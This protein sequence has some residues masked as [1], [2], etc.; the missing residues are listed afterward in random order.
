MFFPNS[1]MIGRKQLTPTVRVL[2]DASDFELLAFTDK[3]DE[4]WLG[5][6]NLIEGAMY[7]VTKQ[8]KE[9][10]LVLND[11]Q[12]KLYHQ[13]CKDLLEGRACR[14]IILKARQLG[15]TTFI[16]A[17]NF[18]LTMFQINQSCVVIANTADNTLN[19]FRKYQNYYNKLKQNFPPAFVPELKNSSGNRME[20]KKTNCSIRVAPSTENAVVGTTVQMI[21]LSE[22]GRMNNMLE[23]MEAILAAVPDTTDNPVTFIFL[24]STARGFNDFKDY[25]DTAVSEQGQAGSFTPMFFP[26]FE[27]KAYRRPVPDNFVLLPHEEEA[28]KKYHLDLEQLAFYREKY[29][30]YKKNL[31]S[32]KQEYPCCPSEAFVSSGSGVFDNDKVGQRKDAVRN[33]K[34]ILGFFQYKAKSIN[35][36]IDDFQIYD[37]HFIKNDAGNTK[38]F[39][40]PKVGVPYVIGVDTAEGSGNDS[41][42]AWVMRNDNKKQVAIMRS[43]ALDSDL[44]ALQIYCLGMFY[45][46]A[47]IGVEN[48]KSTSITAMIKKCNYPNMYK[49]ADNGDKTFDNIY[50]MYG[51]K[52][53]TITKPIMKDIALEICRDC[54]YT[55]IYD[56]QTLTEMESFVYELSDRSDAVKIRGAGQKHDDCVMAMLITYYIANQQTTL[57]E[58]NEV[59]EESKLPFALQSPTEQVEMQE[60]F[61]IWN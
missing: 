33:I 15:F 21:H 49:R 61:Q 5:V 44:A 14:Y 47:L 39:E 31:A 4:K 10:T 51:V 32:L 9:T 43:N 42:V 13:I 1:Q 54:D 56:Y 37:K 52:T 48:N 58:V 19:I 24:E 38:I 57:V 35:Q 7:I 40:M 20:T 26:W 55:N 50:Q 28:R 8:Q 34:P 2:E 16:S 18:V 11:A 12:R 53:T 22:C 3:G 41:T 23:I 45:N 29:L 17:F 6:L 30:G 46:E 60:D 59:K 25:W 27:D 36:G